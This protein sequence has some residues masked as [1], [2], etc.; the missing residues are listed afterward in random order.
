MIPHVRL[1][2]FVVQTK[3]VVELEGRLNFILWGLNND[4]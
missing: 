3:M 4:Q 2:L 1:D